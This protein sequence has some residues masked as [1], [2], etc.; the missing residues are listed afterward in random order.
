MVGRAPG[1]LFAAAARPHWP[2][3]AHHLR[4]RRDY[5]RLL[6]CEGRQR[7]AEH[8]HR[9]GRF[10]F[11][12]SDPARRVG[13]LRE[14]VC[15]EDRHRRRRHGYCLPRRQRPGR[16]R[17]VADLRPQPG[18]AGGV[19]A[20]A[21]QG[22]QADRRL[23]QETSRGIRAVRSAD[24]GVRIA[25]PT[26]SLRRHRQHGERRHQPHP[27][28]RLAGLA[29]R[30]LRLRPGLLGNRA[31]LGPAAAGGRRGRRRRGP[32]LGCVLPHGAR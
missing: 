27:T 3:L 24:R 30:D 14:R 8:C 31:G 15:F 21:L 22:V 18:D 5:S 2:R 13:P 25:Q 9:S 1:A 4:R 6:A 32:R 23:H 17:G 19:G 7:L 20:E 26:L 12:L 28:S 16:L 10:E 29:W 11:G